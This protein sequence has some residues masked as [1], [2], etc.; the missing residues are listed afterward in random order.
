MIYPLADSLK[1]KLR[2]NQN[3]TRPPI[4]EHYEHPWYKTY[5]NRLIRPNPPTTEAVERA[6]FVDRTYH[7]DRNTRN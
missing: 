4:F 5:N 6:K 3:S 2:P 7:W 1:M